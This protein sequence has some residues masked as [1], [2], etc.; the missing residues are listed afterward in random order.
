MAKKKKKPGK[1]TQHHYLSEKCESKNCSE[2]IPET[3]KN[4]H[5]QKK[6]YKQ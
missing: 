3:G 2:V 4:G 5:H 1:D 6:I